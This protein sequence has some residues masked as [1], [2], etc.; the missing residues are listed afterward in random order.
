[1]L[2]YVIGVKIWQQGYFKKMV[3]IVWSVGKSEYA[4]FDR[5]TRSANFRQAAN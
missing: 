3:I 4:L 5:I 1:M 2:L